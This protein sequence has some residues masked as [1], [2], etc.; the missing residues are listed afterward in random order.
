MAVW[1]GQQSRMRLEGDEE[2]NYHL[3]VIYDGPQY[4]DCRAEH[5]KITGR[6]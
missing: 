2:R 6:Q 1:S 5:A 4:A 3:V